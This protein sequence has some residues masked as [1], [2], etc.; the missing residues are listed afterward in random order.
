MEASRGV[1]HGAR[2]AQA[3]S[4]G[5]G[6]QECG[7]HCRVHRQPVGAHGRKKGDAWGYDAGKKITGR[8]RFIGVDTQGLLLSVHIEEASLSESRGAAELLPELAE[9]YPTLRLLWVDGGYA[10]N[11]AREAAE[12]VGIVLEVVPKEPG[13]SVFKVLRRRWVVDRTFAWL[14]RYR[15]LRADYETTTASSRAWIL[16]AMTHLMARRL[17]RC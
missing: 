3:P 12:A 6:G 14:V 8:K 7:A 1:R 10:T 4:A 5:G 13:Q 9:R 2:R 17:R 11:M 15:R 16:L